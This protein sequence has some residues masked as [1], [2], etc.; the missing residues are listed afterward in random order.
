MGLFS[1]HKQ[2]RRLVITFYLFFFFYSIFALQ[3]PGK[4]ILIEISVYVMVMNLKHK[5]IKACR[6][7]GDALTQGR[8]DTV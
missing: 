5:H 3:G 7:T 8:T 4:K 1:R 2:R 6:R